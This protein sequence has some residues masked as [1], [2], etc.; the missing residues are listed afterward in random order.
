VPAETAAVATV[1]VRT[2]LRTV[3]GRTG[4]I[5]APL[6][7]AFF[8]ISFSRPAG[9]HSLDL[10]GSP[11]A[12]TVVVVLVSLQSLTALSSNQFASDGRGLPLL[13]LQPLAVRTLV[14]GKALGIGALQ[15]ACMLLAML[16]VAVLGPPAN[17]SFWLAAIPGGLAALALLAPVSAASSALFPKQV[18]LSRWGRASNPHA[19]AAVVNFLA[20][21]LAVAPLV[22]AEVVVSGLLHRPWLAPLLMAGWLLVAGVAAVLVLPLVERIVGGRRENLALTVLAE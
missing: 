7:A 2:T 10:L 15:L 17:L 16:P 6:L 11:L 4:L 13:F 18:D 12:I 1:Q 20:S 9:R 5:M 22:V 21:G 8:V 14:R 3:R 19:T